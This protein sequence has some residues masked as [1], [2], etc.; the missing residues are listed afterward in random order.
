MHFIITII[1]LKLVLSFKKDIY[2]NNR[3]I[4]R[5]NELFSIFVKGDTNNYR[6]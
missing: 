1:Q 6:F 4:S 2:V 3:S 5:F